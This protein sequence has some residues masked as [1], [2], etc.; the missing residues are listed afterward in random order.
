MSLV[1]DVARRNFNLSLEYQARW[2]NDG[3]STI[4]NG[5]LLVSHKQ[6]N[7]PIP[8]FNA[9]ARV[10]GTNAIQTLETATSWFRERNRPFSICVE[11]GLDKDIELACNTHHFLL[12]ADLPLLFTESN[13]SY[14]LP[15]LPI[16]TSLVKT[17]EDL[18]QFTYVSS[19]AYST[20]GV[21]EATTQS[22]FYNRDE[23]VNSPVKLFV[24]HSKD[25]LIGCGLILFASDTA[26][27]YWV[28]ILPQCR[29][30]GYGNTLICELTRRA[31]EYGARR[32]VLQATPSA[33]RIYR[34]L[35]F[36]ELARLRYYCW[37][38]R[39]PLRAIPRNDISSLH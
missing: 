27:I 36:S 1:L 9:A 10:G 29:G 32:I 8:P 21:P 39:R 2:S 14:D 17:P 31:F 16:E 26:G 22:A 38:Y 4:S 19:R 15:G 35:G 6:S 24:C 30:I 34:R 7:V 3:E 13:W 18:R 28:S 20:A 11:S 23:I 33:E 25:Q 12:C 37:P 5:V